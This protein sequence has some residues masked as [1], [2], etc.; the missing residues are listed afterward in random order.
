MSPDQRAPETLLD[1]RSRRRG[2]ALAD[3]GHGG[4]DARSVTVGATGARSG[5]GGAVMSDSNSVA[6][7]YADIVP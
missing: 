1:R 7:L 2:T 4:S 5:T 6:D 3:P